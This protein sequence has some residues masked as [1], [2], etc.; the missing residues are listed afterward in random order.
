M[1]RVASLRDFPGARLN[2]M[3]V[4]GWVSWWLTEV[5]VA[6]SAQWA[7]ADRGVIV[8]G[9]VLTATPCEAARPGGAAGP[10]TAVAPTASAAPDPA[11]RAP[12]CPAT[13]AEPGALLPVAGATTL[14]VVDTAAVGTIPV[15]I[16]PPPAASN[17]SEVEAEEVAALAANVVLVA[18]AAAVAGVWAARVAAAAAAVAAPFAAA[19]DA[20]VDPAGVAR[21]SAL[22]GAGAM[23]TPLAAVPVLT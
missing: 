10:A 15:V 22:V 13:L 7:K 3:V 23:E 11:A 6:P 17:D 1:A 18:L 16:A 5:G 4:A 19:S 21:A 2:E 20:G 8:S 9:V 14:G 12:G